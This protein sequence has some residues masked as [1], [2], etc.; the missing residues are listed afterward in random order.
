MADETKKKE[1]SGLE[2]LRQHVTPALAQYLNDLN[3]RIGFQAYLWRMIVNADYGHGDVT[4]FPKP[5]DS[6]PPESAVAQMDI[7]STL[8]EE[9]LFCRGVNSFLTY[10]A[11]LVTLIYEKYPKMLQSDKQTSYRFC[12][13]H[14]IAGDLIPALAEKTVM[15]LTHQSLD[16][17][18]RYFEKK[19]DLV[20]FTKNADLAKS[21][22]SVDIR[23]VITHN[24]G[25]VNRFFI[26][27]NPQ[28]AGDLGKRVALDEQHT[29]KMLGTLGYCARQLD[30]RA[31]K[32][33]R[34]ET[35]A[36]Q[37]KEPANAP[38]AE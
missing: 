19:L 36:P 32:K 18:A 6:P 29:Q 27:R 33:F 16:L 23:N 10:L 12:I 7:H 17:L 34:L 15:E 21:A 20:L 3:S 22:L 11:D 38:P 37:F 9:M 28:F 24:R 2:L 1:L 25:I 31:I 30:L 5:G 26:Q 13:E 14:H 4:K 8:L 35:I